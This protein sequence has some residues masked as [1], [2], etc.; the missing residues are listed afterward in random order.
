MFLTTNSFEGIKY[1]KDFNQRRSNVNVPLVKRNLI[2]THHQCG[3]RKAKMQK[4]L[5]LLSP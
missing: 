5:K 4:S 1:E 2:Q 3:S